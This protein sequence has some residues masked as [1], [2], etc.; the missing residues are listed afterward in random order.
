MKGDVKRNT[1]PSGDNPD[2][3]MQSGQPAQLRVMQ[4]DVPAVEELQRISDIARKTDQQ[5]DDWGPTT[6]LSEP[7]GLTLYRVMRG[8]I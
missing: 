8:G 7:R 1:S 4:T 6:D 5:M 2:K 3:M